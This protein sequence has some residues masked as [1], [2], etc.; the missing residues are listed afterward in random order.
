MLQDVEQAEEQLVP[1]THEEQDRLQEEP[2]QFLLR[3]TNLQ[4]TSSDPTGP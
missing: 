3:H 4:D 2:G 1:G